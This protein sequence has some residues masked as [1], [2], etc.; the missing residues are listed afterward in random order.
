MQM[1]RARVFAVCIGDVVDNEIGQVAHIALSLF[2]HIRPPCVCVFVCAF[3]LHIL[4]LYLIVRR[5]AYT[6]NLRM[7]YAGKGMERI[8]EQISYEFNMFCYANIRVRL[9]YGT[10]LS[11]LF[12]PN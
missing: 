1:L 10:N 11:N 9:S 6:T 12:A 7:T 2:Q 3:V 8:F 5:Y 4:Y